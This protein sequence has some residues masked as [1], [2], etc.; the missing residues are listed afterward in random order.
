MEALNPC[1]E[2]AIDRDVNSIGREAERVLSKRIYNTGE[3]F[4]LY[5]Q[6]EFVYEWEYVGY[7][8]E[9]SFD[10]DQYLNMFQ[11]TR[12]NVLNRVRQIEAR[13][14]NVDDQESAMTAS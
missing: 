10:Q 12:V 8:T 3:L 11:F 9:N 5:E 7:D 2:F 4:D 6:I 1:K 14:N 13:I